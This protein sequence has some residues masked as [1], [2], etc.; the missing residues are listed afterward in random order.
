MKFTREDV[1]ALVER[2]HTVA[3]T[4]V[5]G[6]RIIGTAKDYVLVKDEGGRVELIK[7]R[8]IYEVAREVA[9]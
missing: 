6:R 9:A 8:D 7:Y 4:R 1:R 5:G 2:G 3:I